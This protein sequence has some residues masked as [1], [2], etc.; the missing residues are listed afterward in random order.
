MVMAKQAGRK[1]V[2][3]TSGPLLKAAYRQVCISPSLREFKDLDG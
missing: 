1:L 3:D 2:I